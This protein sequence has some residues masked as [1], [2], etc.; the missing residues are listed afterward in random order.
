[1]GA[2][3]HLPSEQLAEETAVLVPHLVGNSIDRHV[4]YLQQLLGLLQTQGMNIFQRRQSGCVRETPFE[5]TLRQ[6]AH[7]DHGGDRRGVS[8]VSAIHSCTAATYR[9]TTICRERASEEKGN[10]P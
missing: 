9:S 1:M 7:L 8:V 5:G 4:S 10:W 3:T 2:E 6:P